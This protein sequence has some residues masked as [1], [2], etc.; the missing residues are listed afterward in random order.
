MREQRKENSMID[1]TKPITCNG[2]PVEVLTWWTRGELRYCLVNY[3]GIVCIM[4][5]LCGSI[6]QAERPPLGT[7]TNTAPAPNLAGVGMTVM[8]DSRFWDVR[9]IDGEMLWIKSNTLGER[10]TIHYEYCTLNGRPIEG[11]KP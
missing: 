4:D 6:T 1:I 11:V 9:G 3:R 2:Q 10:E 5:E 7:A 8:W